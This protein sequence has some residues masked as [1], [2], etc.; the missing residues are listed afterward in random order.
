MDT[1]ENE[2][3]NYVE[4]TM[5]SQRVNRVDT[6]DRKRNRSEPSSTDM[7]NSVIKKPR[8]TKNARR[9]LDGDVESGNSPVEKSVPD[10]SNGVHELIANLS[11]DLHM[12]FAALNERMDK[13]E[14]GLEQKIA[15]KVAQ[16]LDKRVSTEM[17]KIRKD[18][19]VKTSAVKKDIQTEVTAQMKNVNERL[20]VEI[21]SSRANSSVSDDLSLNVVIRGLP[22]SAVENTRN[23]VNSLIKDGL[24]ISGVECIKAERKRNRDSRRPGVIVAKFQSHEDKRSVMMQKKRLNDNRQFNN[25]FI[26]H[27]L[28]LSDR[29]MS[30]N[31]KT[32]LG[33]LKNEGLVLRGSR[34]VKASDSSRSDNDRRCG[35]G[36]GHTYT[37]DRR[38]GNN[39]SDRRGGIDGDFQSSSFQGSSSWQRATRGNNRG[40]NRGNNRGRYQGHN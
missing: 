2:A 17:T 10:T 28:S 35:S 5:L 38:G 4:S 27:D 6:P 37:N 3:A 24:K 9:M 1:A 7:N 25:V 32:I 33:A 13:M 15:T 12:Q 36:N 16:I 8:V 22:E 19:D 14:Q 34:V 29:R 31:F 21:A 40:G 39:H 26:N 11:A 30:E 23:K 18:V 20:K